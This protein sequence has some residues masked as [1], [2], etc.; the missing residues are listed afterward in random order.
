MTL[1]SV[2]FWVELLIGHLFF[3]LYCY[4]FEHYQMYRFKCVVLK[5][6]TLI[7]YFLISEVPLIDLLKFPAQHIWAYKTL[8]IYITRMNIHQLTQT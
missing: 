6:H 5:I 7:Q 4:Y 2:H 8:D 3:R 1:M